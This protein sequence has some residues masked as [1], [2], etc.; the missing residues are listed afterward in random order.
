[1]SAKGSE[2]P[3][4]EITNSIKWNTANGSNAERL[5]EKTGGRKFGRTTF[6]LTALLEIPIIWARQTHPNTETHSIRSAT[7]RV[8]TQPPDKL[9]ISYLLGI[10]SAT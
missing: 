2:R 4:Y 3:F 1:M 10:H 8:F 6:Y 9:T 7:F 5:C